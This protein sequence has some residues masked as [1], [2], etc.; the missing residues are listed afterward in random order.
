MKDF[1]KSNIESGL[2]D[3][4]IMKISANYRSR[5]NIELGLDEYEMI[6]HKNRAHTK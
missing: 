5:N 4:E 6:M 1:R 3:Y 2:D